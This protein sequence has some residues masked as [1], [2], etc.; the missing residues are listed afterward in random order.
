MS[1]KYVVKGMKGGVCTCQ[2]MWRRRRR[3]RRLLYREILLA[4]GFCRDKIVPRAARMTRCKLAFMGGG[5][6]AGALDAE[7]CNRKFAKA[8]SWRDRRPRYCV[9]WNWSGRR[10]TVGE[11]RPGK[12]ARGGGRGK[13]SLNIRLWRGRGLKRAVTPT[14][15]SQPIV[16]GDGQ[17]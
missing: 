15:A 12:E 14:P 2:C 4:G 3:R 7:T 13:Q 17:M 9:C 10:K 5:G 6:V 8:G 11:T 1:N 16:G